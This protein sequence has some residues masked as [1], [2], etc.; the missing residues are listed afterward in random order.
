MKQGVTDLR[1]ERSTF[2]TERHIKAERQGALRPESFDLVTEPTLREAFS[3]TGNPD[4][5]RFE[6]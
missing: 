4:E 2:T 5:P 6:G 1:R 3:F